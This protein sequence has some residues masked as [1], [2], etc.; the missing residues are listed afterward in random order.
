MNVA[1][2]REITEA[3]IEKEEAWSKAERHECRVDGLLPSRL[4][5]DQMILSWVHLAARSYYVISA[6]YNFLFGW[7]HAP[8]RTVLALFTHTA[9]QQ[10]FIFTSRLP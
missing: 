1:N 10:H 8:H 7:H 5:S 9:P 2:G 6:H 4:Y 3:S